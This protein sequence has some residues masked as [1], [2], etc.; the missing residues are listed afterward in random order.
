LN[1]VKPRSEENTMKK[2]IKVVKGN[3]LQDKAPAGCSP[4][5]A[6]K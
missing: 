2:S 3:K 5:Y 4:I 6:P 1:G